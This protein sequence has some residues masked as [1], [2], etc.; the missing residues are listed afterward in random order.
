MNLY[1]VRRFASSRS[2]RLMPSASISSGCCHH[3][4]ESTRLISPTS[5][6]ASRRSVAKTVKNLVGRVRSIIDR[7]TPR[8]RAKRV[9]LT[10]AWRDAIAGLPKW[11]QRKI[12]G[13]ARLAAPVASNR[14]AWA[15]P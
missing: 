8:S 3:R 7:Y 11:E 2:F 1:A 12:V 15:M 13:L 9:P 14:R 6:F 5:V 10:P 4:A